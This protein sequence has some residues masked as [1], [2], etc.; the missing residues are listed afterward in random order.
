MYLEPWDQCGLKG[1]FR[2]SGPAQ[3]DLTEEV[4][5]ELVLEEQDLCI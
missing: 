2:K 5:H 1:S 3:E 4:E